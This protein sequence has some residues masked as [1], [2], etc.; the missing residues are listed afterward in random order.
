MSTLAFR[1]D[2]NAPIFFFPSESDPSLLS[3]S[4]GSPCNLIC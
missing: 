3:Y 1:T 4:G 2:Y